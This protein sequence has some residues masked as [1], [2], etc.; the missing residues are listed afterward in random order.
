MARASSCGTAFFVFV[1]TLAAVGCGGGHPTIDAGRD[2]ALPDGAL[3]DGALPD[4]GTSGHMPPRITMCP[5][6]PLPATASGRCDVTAGSAALL[7]TGDVL[8]PGEVLRGGQVAV[9]GT[10]TITCVAC[11]CSA[12]AAGATTIIC[13]QGVISPGLINAHDHLTYTQDLPFIP[14]AE[15]YE[16]RH[17]WGQGD[18]GHTAIDRMGSAT[19]DEMTWGEMRFVLG[20]ATSTSGA[21]SVAGFLRNVD[22]AANEGLGLPRV[23]LDVFPLG[24]TS[25]PQLASGCGYP[26]IVLSTAIAGDTAYSPHIAE[27]IDDTA[28]N[29]FVCLSVA[30]N[31]VI[32]PQTALIHGTALLPGDFSLMQSRGTSLIWSPRSNISLYADTARVTV[33][34]RL[35]VR[36]A[37]GTDWTA[38]GSPNEL[39]ELACADTFN[40]LYLD[41]FF[42]DE[43]LWLMATSD[44]AAVL[45]LSSRIG[46]IAVGKLADLAIFD[47]RSRADHRAV[48]AAQPEDVM[49]VT[50]A[51]RVLYGDD[52]L[53]S[54]MPMGGTTCE[55]LDVCHTPKRVCTMREV[56]KALA[57]L[58]TSNVAAL[59]LFSCGMPPRE[60]SCLPVRAVTDSV[61][62][63]TYSGM[64]V[65]GDMDGDGVMDAMDSCPRVFDPIRPVDHGML[66]DADHDG[67]GDACDP[68]PLASGAACMTTMGDR[69]ADGVPDDRDNCPQDPNTD[70]A[71]GDM[72]GHGNVCDPCP[73][74]SNVGSAAA[75]AT[76]YQ[77][78]DGTCRDGAVVSLAGAVVTGVGVNGFFAQVPTADAAYAGPDHSGVFVYTATAPTVNVG[79]TFSLATATMTAFHGEMQLMAASPVSTAGGVVPAPVDVGAAEVI[80]GGA[81]ASALEAV[82]VH[83]AG[84]LSVTDTMP[85]PDTFDTVPIN[86]FVVTGGLR[87]DDYLYLSDPF[88]VVSEMFSS[89]TGILALRADDSTL[90]P[91]SA[92]DL[93]YAGPPVLIGIDPALSF[94]YPGM[95]G[96]TIPTPVTV[97]LSRAATADTIVSLVA[98]DTALTVPATV[99]VMAGSSSAVVPVTGV[100]A[101]S[102]STLVTAM[103]GTASYTTHVRVVDPT[104]V[105]VLVSLTPDTT[106]TDTGTPVTLTATIDIPAPA[107]GTT[108]TLAIGAGCSGP[109]MVVIPVGAL[110]ATVAVTCDGTASPVTVM[111]TA[112]A[113]FSSMITVAATPHLLINE[114]DYD[115]PSPPTSDSAEYIE[116]VN[117]GSSV[118][119]LTGVTL[120]LVNG[121][122]ATPAVYATYDLS[123]I[124]MLP[125]GGTL[126][127]ASAGVTLGSGAHVLGLGA[128]TNVIQ[129]GPNDGM[130]LVDTMRHV[131]I[132]SFSYEGGVATV[133]LPVIGAVSLIHGA[134]STV[135]DTS[136]VAESLCRIPNAATTGND[137]A[138]W[139]LCTTL[140]PGTPNM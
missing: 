135:A 25:R 107:G 45:G 82:L 42:D 66:A 16:Q 6:Y 106:T 90:E 119:D 122:I 102:T 51:G 21:G 140:T 121:G 98:G 80:T 115:Q 72:D 37:L 112:G 10:G 28:R 85:V 54:A 100:T 92:A 40:S 24:D 76:I 120:Y 81:R 133:T 79:D 127:V 22:T 59:P 83:V 95:T 19:D 129:N 99:S 50:R 4:G 20:G 94:Q 70:Q 11:D 47:A 118:A 110:S 74:L 89:A 35:G 87:V 78:K 111:A 46:T 36:I 7:I 60:P 109:S 41:H 114:V 117:V 64:S 139:R 101:A 97:H 113:T 30:P 5:G 69:D 124:G 23:D 34:S 39:R 88:P 17:D 93:P 75:A 14:T 48:I 2:A 29:E 49:L 77:V 96:P 8:T 38:S 104:T 9:D 27:G 103:L 128:V 68:C 67:I 91:R 65:L 15:R 108:V 126:V 131:V 57:T 3:P 32:Q 43:Q 31:D 134:A 53:V 13:P 73:T 105:P 71:D 56:G 33:A 116:I 136:T 138:D 1:S 52:A 26:S 18:R 130:A 125:A 61:D 62:S 132:D 63:V 84:P 44:A 123:S 58:T 86:E 12:M 137:M 55:M